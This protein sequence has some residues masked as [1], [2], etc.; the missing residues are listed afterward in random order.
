M[1]T[2]HPPATVRALVSVVRREEILIIFH[3]SQAIFIPSLVGA[4]GGVRGG[5]THLTGDTSDGGGRTEP[6]KLG[7]ETSQLT[8]PRL[9]S[10]IWSFRVK[11]GLASYLPATQ[12]TVSVFLLHSRVSNEDYSNA[13]SLTN[14]THFS[15]LNGVKSLGTRKF[16]LP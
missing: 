6:R 3:P 7:R 4:A 5:H 16:Q 14:L 1:N 11:S 15:P 10:N 8:E 12:F 13:R 2:Q 9:Y